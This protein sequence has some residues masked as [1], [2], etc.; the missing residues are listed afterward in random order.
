MCPF[1]LNRSVPSIEVIDTKTVG[2]F[3][4]TNFVSLEWKYPESRG[5]PK[6]QGG[7]CSLRWCIRGCAAEQ[8][9]VFVLSVLNRVYNF[10]KVC[11]KQC[12]CP[13]IC[14]K[15]GNKFEGFFPKQGQVSNPQRLTYSKLLVEYPLGLKERFHCT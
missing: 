15:Q 4:R 13:L 2:V 11:L 9:I 12:T 10:A 5:V 6:A 1:P 8:G 14:R 7:G 3:R